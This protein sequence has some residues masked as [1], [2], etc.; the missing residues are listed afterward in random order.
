MILFKNDR[1]TPTDLKKL[2]DEGCD[3]TLID[4]REELEFNLCKI[5]G[6]V[7]LP[8]RNL[9][10]NLH[11]VERS[12]PIVTICHHGV[13]SMQAALILR[14]HGFVYVTSLDGGLEKWAVEIDKAMPRY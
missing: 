6:S 8:L 5:Y 14:E 12:K 1:I 3:I 10:Q 9:E 4:V 13:R 2:L 11:K 7:N